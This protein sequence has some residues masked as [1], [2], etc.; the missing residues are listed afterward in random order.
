MG[1]MLYGMGTG[2]NSGPAM[3]RPRDLD[4]SLPE[5]LEVLIGKAVIGDRHHRPADLGALAS[6]LYHVAPQK[7]IHPPDISEAR[8]DASADAAVAVR[9][10]MLPPST[11]APAALEA[12]SATSIPRAPL[13]P[14][15]KAGISSRAPRAVDRRA[16]APDGAP[17]S[18][19]SAPDVRARLSALKARL[20][21]G[22]RPRYGVN[23]EGMDYGPLRSGV[24]VDQ[25]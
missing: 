5:A 4:P 21:G 1:A 14:R 13:I 20:R 10:S 24:L 23:K 22:P 8:L 2:A 17:S 16:S 11:V 25:V 12:S 19:R 6:A 18:R 7:S 3:K 9:F 15:L